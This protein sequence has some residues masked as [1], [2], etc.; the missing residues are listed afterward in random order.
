MIALLL[1]AALFSDTA[2]RVEVAFTAPR[3]AAQR[4]RDTVDA[5][6]TGPVLT[7]VAVTLECTAHADGRV[8]G[9][10]VLGET[11]P[12][13]G[14][15]DAALALMRGERVA[16]GARDVQFAKTIQFVP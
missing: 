11:H 10:S 1:A 3:P 14:F 16:P 13:L 15:G 4:V 6:A 5:G 12:G 2:P 8:D 9:C 7:A